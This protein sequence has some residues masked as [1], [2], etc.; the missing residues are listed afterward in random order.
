MIQNAKT[1]IIGSSLGPDCDLL[2]ASGLSFARSIGADTEVLH[3]YSS[4][5]SIF[6]TFGSPLMTPQIAEGERQGLLRALNAQID[7]LVTPGTD[8]APPRTAP[9]V[10]VHIAEG[11]A[12]RMLVER[13]SDI[14]AALIILGSVETAKHYWAFSP[15]IDY[16]V[17]QAPCP[18]LILRGGTPLV[19]NHVLA[20][21]DLSPTTS[22]EIESCLDLLAPLEEPPTFEL[23]FALDPWNQAGLRQFRQDQ[24]IGFTE[25]ELQRLAEIFGSRG[26]TFMQ[27]KVRVGAPA[28]EILA[29][30]EDRHSGLVLIGT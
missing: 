16:V 26:G 8:G 17:R 11:P 21:I 10:N 2:V 22:Q 1:V 28:S 3:A 4:I 13:A 7:P 6:A 24:I 27:G 5:T 19:T 15:T 9:R 14:D 12:Y 20:P 30:I 23:M 25:A 18:V 29:E